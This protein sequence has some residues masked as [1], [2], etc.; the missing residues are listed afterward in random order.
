MVVGG[1]PSGCE[2]ALSVEA[3]FRREGIEGRV[4]LVAGGGLVPELPPGAARSVQRVL[5]R[6]GVRLVSGIRAS[7]AGPGGV[8]LADGRFL[9]ADVVVDASGVVPPP[10]VGR[11]G[12]PVDE[13]GALVVDEHL[14]SPVDGRVFGAGDC[15]AFCGRGLPRVGVHAVRQAPV[16]HHNLV[17][18]ADG[19]GLRRYRP[20][21]RVLLILNLGDG[22]GLATWGPFHLTGRLPFLLK[23]RLDRRFLEKHRPTR[24]V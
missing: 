10:V 17:A 4:D 5:E 20:P 19:S 21:G 22:T 24:R 15:V 1:G 3:L 6:R 8:T 7:A 14:R 2:V 18:A 9:E 11:L 12:L 16:L 23:D 13:E